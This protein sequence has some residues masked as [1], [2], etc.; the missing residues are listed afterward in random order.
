MTSDL[1]GIPTATL[2]RLRELLD[3]GRFALP[4]RA[5]D[6]ISHDIGTHATQLIDCLGAFDRPACL[7]VLAITLAERR[8]AFRP[9]PELVWTGPEADGSQSRDTAV[10]LR[11]LFLSARR[12]VV[13][14]GAYFDHAEQVLAPL[15]QCMLRHG[16]EAHLFV[17]VEQ[18]KYAIAEPED[19]GREA[20]SRFLRHHWPFGD[21]VPVLYCDRRSLLP[22][23]PYSSLHAKCVTV[24]A[25]RAFVSSA[26]FTGRGQD[27]NIEV[28]LLLD[29]ARFAQD[30]DAAWMAFGRSSC[31]LQFVR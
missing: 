3:K 11:E 31:A 20:L 10:V 21:P 29:D 17:G 4:L 14:A 13:M 12:R 8:A 2:E 6:L 18:P 24:D 26:N 23:P 5:A 1:S 16:V 22:G 28:G 9:Q 25:E 19:S 15:H 27:R 30:L 7:A